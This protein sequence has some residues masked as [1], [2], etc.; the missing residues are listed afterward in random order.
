MQG[1]GVAASALTAEIASVHSFT[2]LAFASGSATGRTIA[3]D[4]TELDAFRL[5]PY[6]GPGAAGCAD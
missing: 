5:R 6:P 3:T 2:T 4:G 1:K